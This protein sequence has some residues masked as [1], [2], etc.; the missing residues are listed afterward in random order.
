MIP[1]E[2]ATH[3]NHT[4]GDRKQEEFQEEMDFPI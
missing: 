2:V 1:M 3:E 4:C